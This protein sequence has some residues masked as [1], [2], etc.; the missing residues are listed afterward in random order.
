MSS[1]EGYKKSIFDI[2]G[3]EA[4]N[5]RH[6]YIIGEVQG[7]FDKLHSSKSSKEMLAHHE[8]M[9]SV[10]N[11][12]RSMLDILDFGKTE[13]VWF[14][15]TIDQIFC[16]VLQ[17]SENTGIVEQGTWVRDLIRRHDDCLNSKRVVDS[18][19]P[20]FTQ[21]LED[22]DAQEFVVKEVE[23]RVRMLREQHD[24]GKLSLNCH[25]KDAKT[26][27][28]KQNKLDEELRQSRIGEKELL[29]IEHIKASC[30]S[31][32]AEIQT[33]IDSLVSFCNK[34]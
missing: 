33:L 12:L 13:L 11:V 4:K 28:R 24:S 18:D 34:S 2:F 26:S 22:L 25:I 6:V 9:K 23:E 16:C 10:F 5:F 19:L 32:E 20:N 7:I 3:L 27:M 31:Q 30:K 29:E 1:L 8:G 17:I 21:E 14:V 15:N